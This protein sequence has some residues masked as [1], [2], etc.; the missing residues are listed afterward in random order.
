MYT[1]TP[2]PTPCACPKR[3]LQRLTGTISYYPSPPR[4]HAK[5]SYTG[6]MCFKV[7]GSDP[8]SVVSA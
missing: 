8:R 7:R 2:T 1:P 5:S 3:E 6:I 4:L